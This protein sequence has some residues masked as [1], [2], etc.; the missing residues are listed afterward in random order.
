MFNLQF[1]L[2]KFIMKIKLSLINFDLLR[3]INI[4]LVLFLEKLIAIDSP[5]P[6]LHPVINAVLFL[7]LKSICN[8]FD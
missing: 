7:R 3:E 5:M 1:I 2:Y 8:N 6:A 4:H